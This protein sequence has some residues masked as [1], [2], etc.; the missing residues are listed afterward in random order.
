MILMSLDKQTI[1][2]S[3]IILYA[4]RSCIL[5]AGA[6]Y[7][8]KFSQEIIVRLSKKVFGNYDEITIRFANTLKAQKKLNFKISEYNRN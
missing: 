3:G 5:L 2:V 7:Q 4:M 6:W 1:L 8:A